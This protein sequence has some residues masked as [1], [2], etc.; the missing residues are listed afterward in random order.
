MT[1][2]AKGTEAFRSSAAE[3]KGPKQNRAAVCRVAFNMPQQERHF[4]EHQ[5]GLLRGWDTLGQDQGAQE[6]ALGL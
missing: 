2:L 4:S 5:L 1:S 6:V 3:Q